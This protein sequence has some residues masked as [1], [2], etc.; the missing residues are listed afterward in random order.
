MELVN[1]SQLQPGHVVASA[2]QNAQGAVL[3]PHGFKLTEEAIARL[4]QAGVES[5]VIMGGLAKGPDVKERLQ[6]LDARFS[7]VDDVHLLEIKKV[8]EQYF[9]EIAS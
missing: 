2:V 7:H 5:V 1:I 9:Q 8:L 4:K 6:A 3:C